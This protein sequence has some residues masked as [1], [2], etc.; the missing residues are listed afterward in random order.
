MNNNNTV[1][2]TYLKLLKAIAIF[3]KRHLMVTSL[4]V[5]RP[6]AL[7]LKEHEVPC[8]GTVNLNYSN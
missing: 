8:N 7:R 1:I 6:V 3:P 2:R 4:N 5:R